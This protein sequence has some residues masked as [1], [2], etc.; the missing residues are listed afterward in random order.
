MAGF[1]EWTDRVLD[2][3]D[4]AAFAGIVAVTKQRDE[5]QEFCLSRL[6][7]PRR[8][9]MN[10]HRDKKE[11]EPYGHKDIDESEREAGSP[12]DSVVRSRDGV[13]SI[14][15]SKD[16]KRTAG[17]EQDRCSS[18]EA[19]NPFGAGITG[20]EKTYGRHRDGYA[21]RGGEPVDI[22]PKV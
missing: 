16:A 4:R 19:A 1:L 8:A 17:G 12:I 10:K 18:Q 15:K 6:R 7:V 5:A 13:G 21:E 3:R 11:Q 22:C 14:P 20:E 2:H 9:Q